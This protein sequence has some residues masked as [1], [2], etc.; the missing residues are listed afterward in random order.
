MKKSSANKG[1]ILDMLRDRVAFLEH[2]AMETRI[3][4]D[5]LGE[6]EMDKREIAKL[7]AEIKAG[8]EVS[9]DTSR[10]MKQRRGRGRYGE[11]R[12]AKKVGGKV[13][14]RSKY[15]CF[16]TN[17][18]QHIIQIN[19]QKPPDVVTEMFSFES[20]WLKEAP[21]YL[22]RWVGQAIANCPQGLTPILVIGDR[23]Q[24]EVYY[25]MT[26]RGWLD[27]HK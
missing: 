22:Q 16:D 23:E 2:L 17:Y 18:G 19:C 21:K 6:L 3:S 24:R 8:R 13:V 25:I 11:Q 7:E 20:K 14:G 26:E 5:E 15:I 10:E 4:L 27:L 9:E 12:L 1:L